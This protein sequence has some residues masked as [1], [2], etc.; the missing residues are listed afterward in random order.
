MK[1][2]MGKQYK[3]SA[4]DGLFDTPEGRAAFDKVLTTDAAEPYPVVIQLK[5]GRIAS[6]TSTGGWYLVSDT[7]P[8][9][10]IEVTT[11]SDF[12]RG[13][14]VMASDNGVY[15]QRRHFSH[16]Q[17]GRPVCFEGGESCWTSS[18]GVTCEWEHCR[19]PTPEE[20]KERG[21]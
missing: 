20:L 1:I 4:P 3:S 11:F 8:N 10:L 7:H 17:N 13:E 16:E 6:V 21:M 2:E 14:P 5:N 12:K 19:R 15:W 18:D 9:D